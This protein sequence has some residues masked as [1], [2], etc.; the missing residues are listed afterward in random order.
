VILKKKRNVQWLN[1]HLDMIIYYSYNTIAFENIT[2]Y[3]NP[4]DIS[5][6]TQQVYYSLKIVASFE[7]TTKDSI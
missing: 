6:K 7:T 3:Y 2:F 1:Q 4:F 5:S